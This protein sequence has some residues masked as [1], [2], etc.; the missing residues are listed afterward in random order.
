M[1]LDIL[2][3]IPPASIKS[4][5]GASCPVALRLLENHPHRNHPSGYCSSPQTSGTRT[6]PSPHPHHCPHYPRSNMRCNWT[7]IDH[8]GHTGEAPICPLL[9]SHQSP[10]I[11]KCIRFIELGI[12]TLVSL[13]PQFWH[14]WKPVPMGLNFAQ[15]DKEHQILTTEQ[16]HTE[17][18]AKA[19]FFAFSIVGGS[20]SLFGSLF[21]SRSS[22]TTS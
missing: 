16:L 18:Q 7:R 2:P 9:P 22:C 19:L 6:S 17:Q 20:C 10:S 15:L 5:I 13:P 14:S 1:V 3:A 21:G 8:A 11:Q 12:N 4:T